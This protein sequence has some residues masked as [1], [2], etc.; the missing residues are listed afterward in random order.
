MT[1]IMI[2][3]LTAGTGTRLSGEGIHN[4]LARNVKAQETDER[5]G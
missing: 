3:V 1:E 4:L 2:S 5:V